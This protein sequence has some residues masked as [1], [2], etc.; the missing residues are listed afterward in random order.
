MRGRGYHKMDKAERERT[1]KKKKKQQQQQ[2]QRAAPR[3]DSGGDP[4]RRF[5]Q[6]EIS[7]VLSGKFATQR[8]KLEGTQDTLKKYI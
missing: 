2:Q 1:K 8:M 3:V 5:R 4:N 7:T 6:S